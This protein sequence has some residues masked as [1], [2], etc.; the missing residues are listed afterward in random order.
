M[1]SKALCLG[2]LKSAQWLAAQSTAYALRNMV[3]SH[4]SKKMKKNICGKEIC[5]ILLEIYGKIFSPTND[6]SLLVSYIKIVKFK[7]RECSKTGS[8]VQSYY[9]SNFKTFK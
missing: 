9:N 1:S 4:V 3:N 7:D 2:V 8:R 5:E 6:Y